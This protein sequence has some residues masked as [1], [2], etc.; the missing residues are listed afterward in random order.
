MKAPRWIVFIS[1]RWFSKGEG[2]VHSQSS[3]LAVLG[4]AAGT[5]A[6]I[7]VM[8]VMNGLQGGYIDALL[9][10]SSFHIRISQNEAADRAF[11]PAAIQ[12]NLA[13]MPGIRSILPFRES[14]VL[15]DTAEGRVA[16][17]RIMVIPRDFD[18]RDPGFAREL[19]ID[20][21]AFAKGRGLVMGAEAARAL[22][23]RQGDRFDMLLPSSGLEEGLGIERI[24][25]ALVSTF[26]SGFWQFDSGLALLSEADFPVSLA[27]Q[28]GWRPLLGIKLTDRFADAAIST[29]IS[30]R[31]ASAGFAGLAI[32]SWRDYNRAFFGALGTE[33]GMMFLL[34]SLVFLVVASN[35]HH[36]MRRI[37]AMRAE[38]IAILRS[39]GASEGDLAGI[40][41]WNGLWTG[42]RGAFFGLLAGSFISVNINEIIV[43]GAR[44]IGALSSLVSTILPNIPAPVP[45]DTVFY[46]QELPVR[47]ELPETF[48]VAFL[49]IAAA[50]IASVSA[51]RELSRLVPVEILRHE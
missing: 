50:L 38:D 33:K 34:L 25:L 28:A 17:L 14:M 45:L 47:F 44:A 21:S 41:V 10:V 35:I 51:S 20:G 15:V 1:R 42:I 3:F 11:D 19:G 18:R 29:A 31:L 2:S 24:S 39:I 23:L 8:A 13:G 6:L 30:R 37:V 36:V 5:T 49:A 26:T 7:V 22:G 40:F 9:E 46:L 4:I 32:E 12:T 48:L 43:F 16:P 27:S